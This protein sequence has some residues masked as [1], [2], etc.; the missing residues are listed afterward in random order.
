VLVT[1]LK[2]YSSLL[3]LLVILSAC[4]VAAS[5]T[6]GSAGTSAF[7]GVVPFFEEFNENLSE[8]NILERRRINSDYS[9]VSVRATVPP[10]K[11]RRGVPIDELLRQEAFGIFVTES[12]SSNH[13][14]T[15]DIFPS[16]SFHDYTVNMEEVGSDY[17]VVARRSVDY[18][19]LDGKVKYFYDLRDREV[20][21]KILHDPM[22]IYSIVQF[23]NTLFFVGSNDRM[24][25][26]T[27]ITMLK[28]PEASESSE[29]YEIIDKIDG[30]TIPPIRTVDNR[31]TQLVFVSDADEFAFSAGGWK[32]GRNPR[33][34]LFKPYPTR[35]EVSGLP[36]LTL[37]VP[38][39]RVNENT[40]RVTVPGQPDRR[41]LIWNS[42]VSFN[43]FGGEKSNGI[44]EITGD[45]H[46]FHELPRPDYEMFERCRPATVASASKDYRFTIDADIGAFQLTDNKIWLGTRFYD[47]EWTTG[48]GGLGYFDVGTRQYHM[49]YPREI[50]DWSASSIYVDAPQIWLGLVCHTEGCDIAGGLIRYDRQSETI[51]KYPVPNVINVIGRF[52]DSLYLGMSEGI[53]ILRNG[54]L[55]HVGFTFDID[56]KYVVV[57]KDLGSNSR[58][59]DGRPTRNDRA[60]R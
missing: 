9:L 11:V 3:V 38:L 34:E 53:C 43:S 32:V 55:T 26:T 39:Y 1:Q 7:Y 14:M 21:R 31:G 13:H 42:S 37:S 49:T 56:G 8:F 10:D 18:G 20:L 48:V 36:Y 52:G 50:V 60:G 17:A 51:T 57:C 46:K 45:A 22:D 19:Y 16:G 35:G 4:G 5:S 27:V 6:S 29:S 47:G 2:R 30:R 23:E 24:K 58:E 15:I 28:S 44:Y 25:Q 59:N 40:L 54:R 33:P 41:F 12:T